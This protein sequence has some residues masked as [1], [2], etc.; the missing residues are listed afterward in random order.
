MPS[1]VVVTCIPRFWMRAVLQNVTWSARENHIGILPTPDAYVHSVT[2]S[3]VGTG[4]GILKP[5][6]WLPCAAR[7]ES[8]WQPKSALMPLCSPS[9]PAAPVPGN[10]RS[11]L[12]VLEFHVSRSMQYVMFCIWVLLLSAML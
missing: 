9:P 6:R 11:A 5:S 1:T 10:N 8:H 3:G 12:W 2:I 7:A 4:T